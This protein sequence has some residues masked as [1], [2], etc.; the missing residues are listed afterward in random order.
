VVIADK[1]DVHRYLR[2]Y[3]PDLVGVSCVSA[4][5]PIVRDLLTALKRMRPELP[6][7]IGGHHATFMYKEVFADTGVDYVCRGEGEEVFPALLDSLEKGEKH[8]SIPGIV[9]RKDGSFHN[10]EAIALLGDINRLPRITLDLVAPEFSFSPKIVSSRGCPFRCSFCSISAFYNGRYRQRRVEDVI[11]DIEEY[12]SWGFNHFWFHDD[13]LTVDTRW[14]NDFCARI[15]Q[16]GMKFRWNCMSRVDTIVRDPELVARMARCGCSLVSIGIESGIPE[17][18]ERMHKKIDIPQIKTAIAILNRLKISHNWYMILGS[19]DEFDQHK[20]LK[21]NIR[22]FS[23]LPFGY[24][25]ISILTPFPGTEIFEKLRSE[26]RLLHYNWE[27]YD[28][29]HC[30]YQPYGMSA[31]ELESYLLKAYLKVYLSKGWRLIPLFIN[32]FRS[33]AIRPDMIGHALKAMVKAVFL[34]MDFHSAISKQR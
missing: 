6:T 9:F 14:V 2:R 19:A 15:E 3:Q 29:T 27:D 5:Y 32:S 21:Q 13:N 17:V 25:L 7:I 31:K 18:L 22:F 28:A 30:V 12:I 20:Y 8:P 33:Q 1:N 16:R 26:N 11:A 23:S 34:R 4:T 24:V 10:D